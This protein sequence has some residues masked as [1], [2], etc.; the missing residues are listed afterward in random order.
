METYPAPWSLKGKG[1]IILFKFSKEDIKSDVFLS[2]F[3]KNNYAGGFA[4]LMIVEYQQSNAGPYNEILF[5]PGKFNFNGKRKNTI[6][7]IYV[8]TMLSVENGIRNWG[9]PKELAD[10]RF[11][12]LDD[13][14]EQVFASIDGEVFF[15][16]EFKKRCLPLPVHTGFLPFPLVQISDQKAFFTKFKGHG[17]GNPVKINLLESNSKFFP[18]LKD[19]KVI[20]AIKAE[21]FSIVFPIPDVEEFESTTYTNIISKHPI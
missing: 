18:D 6:S 7:K 3:F 2:D 15:K 4:S 1:Y 13:R 11:N 17:K 10:I 14:T 12:K 21:P 19:K 5:I 20:F 9:I 16:A 8:S